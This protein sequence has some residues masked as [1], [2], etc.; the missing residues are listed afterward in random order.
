MNPTC[1]TT[2][3]LVFS[4]LRWDSD[5][6]RPQHLFSR[7]AKHRRVFYFEDP[8]YG[9][10]DRPRLHLRESEEGVHIVVPYL[11]TEEKTQE[12]ESALRELVDELVLDEINGRY[13]V[14]Y[15]GTKAFPYSRHLNPQFTIFDC[16]EEGEKDLEAE[17]LSRAQL[18]FTA[19]EDLLENLKALHFNIHS[20]PNSI[21]YAHYS[22]G[23]LQIVEPDD[24]AAIPKPRI[25]VYG[26]FDERLLMR[27]I[28]LKPDY[29]FVVI[30]DQD[31][32][33][34]PRLHCLG[35]KDYH[36]VPSYLSGWDCA[37]LLAPRGAQNLVRASEFLAAG[38]PVVTTPIREVSLYQDQ[39]LIR[40]A[41]TADEFAVEIDAAIRDRNND[42]EWLERVDWFLSTHSWDSVFA[43][44]A[45]LESDTIRRLEAA[46]FTDPL[47]HKVHIQ[48][49]GVI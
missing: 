18:V 16:D 6:Q 35:S 46:P 44:M 9:I 15:E 4:S 36:I 17:L 10:T 27:L 23:R 34:A 31:C 19:T 43:R 1:E 25:G 26:S 22:Q 5:F 47:I 7:Y 20:F 30:G 21:D 28:E 8:I 29:N 12:V 48:A 32:G 49:S 42:P 13:T 40:T 38:R 24:Q 3:L 37:I 11:P 45:R 2:D 39:G 41:I 33:S 14:W